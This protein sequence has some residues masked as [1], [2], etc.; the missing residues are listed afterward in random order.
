MNFPRDFL[1]VQNRKLWRDKIRQ[2]SCS[3]EY[4]VDISPYEIY[5][6]LISIP[7]RM[8]LVLQCTKP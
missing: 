2:H 8:R 4:F 6:C 3:L 5:V 7:F 1:T